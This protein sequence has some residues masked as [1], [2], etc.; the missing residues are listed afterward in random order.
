MV[1]AFVML[2]VLAASVIGVFIYQMNESKR[3][4]GV[5][6]SGFNL[7]LDIDTGTVRAPAAPAQEQSSLKMIGGAPSGMKFGTQAAAPP[8]NLQG[9][10]RNTNVMNKMQG[11]AQ[12]MDSDKK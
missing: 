4:S 8:P 9:S 3:K 5:D 10:K 12:G 2:A 11:A 6:T 1:L 7:S